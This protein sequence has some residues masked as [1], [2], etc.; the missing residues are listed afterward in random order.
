MINVILAF[1]TGFI[2]LLFIFVTAP[3]HRWDSKHKSIYYTKYLSV[4]WKGSGC[5]LDIR[6]G[7]YTHNMIIF[8]GSSNG[9]RLEVSFT[10]LSG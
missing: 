9:K 1:I 10:N 3:Y 8:L 7:T 6:I 2:I 5:R 4:Y